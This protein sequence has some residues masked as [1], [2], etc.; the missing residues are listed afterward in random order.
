VIVQYEV[1]STDYILIDFLVIKFLSCVWM[2][3]LG[4]YYRFNHS[5]SRL[6]STSPQTMCGLLSCMRYH[7]HFVP[8]GKKKHVLEY[9][10]CI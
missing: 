10:F 7:L 2:Y 1:E 8:S 5:L 6:S 9:N 3:I 4:I